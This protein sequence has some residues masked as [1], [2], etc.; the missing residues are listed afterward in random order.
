MSGI[1]VW[2]A[3]LDFNDFGHITGWHKII[4]ENDDSKLP[5]AFAREVVE[6]ISNLK[7]KKGMP[8]T[9]EPSKPQ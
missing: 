3:T 9:P 1:S 7:T 2:N 6:G 8:S 4:S 5:E